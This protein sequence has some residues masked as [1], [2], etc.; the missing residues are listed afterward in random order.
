MAQIHALLLIANE[1]MSSEQILTEL[2]ISTGNVNMNIRAL[3][4]WG[5]VYKISKDGERC[6]FYVAE[7]IYTWFSNKYSSIVKKRTG[8]NPQRF[9]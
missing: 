9:K 8:S 1:P 3:L 5:L 6:E 4:D 7:K 2:A